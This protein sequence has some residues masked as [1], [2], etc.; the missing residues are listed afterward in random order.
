MMP[1]MQQPRYMGPQGGYMGHAPQMM[2]P[3]QQQGMMMPAMQMQQPMMQAA[4]A[5]VARQEAAV[6]NDLFDGSVVSSKT[7]AKL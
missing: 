4:P 5:A 2:M 6:N 7:S 1:R 3:M